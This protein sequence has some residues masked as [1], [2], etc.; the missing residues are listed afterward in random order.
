MPRDLC[1]LNAAYMTPLTLGQ[2]AAGQGA[3]AM[4]GT[5]WMVGPDDFFTTTEAI[6]GQGASIFNCTADDLAIVPAA[7]YGIAT[8]ARNLPIEKGQAVLVLEGQFPSNVYEWRART[9]EVGA[10]LVTVAPPSDDDWTRAVLE[11]VVALGDHLAIAALPHVHWSSGAR[12]DLVAIGQAVR[13]AGGALV[14]DLT[15][16]LG[17]MPFDAGAVDPDFAVA[18]GYK[19]LLGPYGMGLMYVAP[20][21]QHGTA[22]EQNWIVRRDS[23]DFAGLVDYKD[24]YQ[25]GARRFDVGERSNF[26]LAPIFHEGLRQL[27]E[28]GVGNV[29]ESLNAI[30]T[31]LGAVAEAAGLGP[32][33]ESLRG[34]HMTGIHC[35]D[36]GPA[37]LAAL[38]ERG[39][40]ASLRGQ[41]LRLAPHLWID[42][43][44]EARFEEAV[45]AL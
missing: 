36:R 17:A 40:S 15:Q 31:R 10:E 2:Q 39:V 7:S 21:H 35:G 11:R 26:I 14:L 45:K 43:A 8:A 1:Y 24:D 25:P 22:L 33:A 37:L 38:K 23:E 6:R 13:A 44:D 20:R 42:E 18:A 32:I 3:L 9:A 4:N 29:A 16:S 28:W 12:L 27:L 41:T 30:N 19:W 34:P 5:P